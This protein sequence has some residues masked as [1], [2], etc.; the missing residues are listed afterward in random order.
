VLDLGKDENTSVD[1][2]DMAEAVGR[3]VS[4]GEADRGILVSGMGLIMGSICIVYLA[5]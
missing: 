1:Y 5:L 2:P 3:M 4:R